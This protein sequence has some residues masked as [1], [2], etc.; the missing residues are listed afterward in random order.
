MVALVAISY[1]HWI[2]FVGAVLILLALDLG[3]FHRRAHVVGFRESLL[4]TSAWVC[5]A[6]LFAFGLKF[7]RGQK[8]ALEFLTGYFI[9]ISLSMDNVF[10]IALIFGHFAIPSHYQH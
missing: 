1:W 5:L 7:L 9:E 6:L 10:V 4:W 2:G 8:E 3:V